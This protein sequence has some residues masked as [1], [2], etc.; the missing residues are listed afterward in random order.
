[1]SRSAR[2]TTVTLWLAG[3]FAPTVVAD[4]LHLDSGDRG[5]LGESWQRRLERLCG[6]KLHI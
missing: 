4:T 3:E 5:A 1:M 2:A 6:L